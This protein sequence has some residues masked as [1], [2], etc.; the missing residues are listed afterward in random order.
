MKR[1]R[2]SN[3]Q[4]LPSPINSVHQ[5][6]RLFDSDDTSARVC[7]VVT[8]FLVT[9]WSNSTLVPVRGR[10]EE[11]PLGDLFDGEEFLL[12]TEGTSRLKPVQPGN[13]RSAA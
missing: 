6:V 4:F 1:Q 13:C 7:S 9:T 10:I 2:G 8:D 11:W 3:T 12:M 5:T